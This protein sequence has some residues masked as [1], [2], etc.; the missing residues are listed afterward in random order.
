MLRTY[1]SSCCNPNDQEYMVKIESTET[2]MNKND[3]D[4]KKLTTKRS[5]I[6][7]DTTAQDN[8]NS[9]SDNKRKSS[10]QTD[11]N[12]IENILAVNNINDIKLG[13]IKHMKGN[14]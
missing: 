6:Q 14:F 2:D 12:I 4:S 13:Q 8:P 1:F 11:Q 7:K 10:G 3:T 9:L 5:T